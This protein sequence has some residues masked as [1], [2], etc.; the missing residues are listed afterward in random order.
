VTLFAGEFN[1]TKNKKLCLV[2]ILCL[3]LAQQSRTAPE[4][5]HLE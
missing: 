1:A 2:L 5:Q 3:A 4:Q